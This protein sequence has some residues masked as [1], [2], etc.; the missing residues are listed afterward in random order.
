MFLVCIVISIQL[1]EVNF[2][3]I[4][5]FLHYNLLQ[6][7][8]AN[9]ILQETF[10]FEHPKRLFRKHLKNLISIF[11]FCSYCKTSLFVGGNTDLE[12]YWFIFDIWNKTLIFRN[13]V[14][15]MDR[16]EWENVRSLEIGEEPNMLGL[17][18]L[19]DRS[20]TRFV[21]ELLLNESG[22]CLRFEMEN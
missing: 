15:R 12:I 9:D 6:H 16:F 2:R 3:P 4:F 19:F 5:L 22:F 21:F 10:A 14:G 8:Y 13:L 17:E 18:Y 1:F 20:N 7:F 11:F